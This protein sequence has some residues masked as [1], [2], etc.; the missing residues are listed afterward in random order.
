[1]NL[2][3]EITKRIINMIEKK[4]S[5]N[6]NI[7]KP[8]TTK[9]VKQGGVL[10]YLGKQKTVNAPRHWRSSPKHPI[11]HLS[12]ITKD[13]EKILIDLN[14]YGSL[15]GKPNR[16]PFG[17]PSLQGS[18][19]GSGG[20]GGSSGGDGSSSGDSSGDSSG[21][22]DSSGDGDSSG[23][24]DS[25]PGG[26]D[27]GSGHGGP[28]PGD[29]G[30][31]MG[32]LGEVGSLGVSDVSGMSVGDVAGTS[33]NAGMGGV[34]GSAVGA[35]ATAAAAE[36]AEESGL[37]K[38]MTAV[39]SYAMNPTT[40]GRAIG[41][42][43]FGIPGAVVGS[44]IGSNIG[45]GVTGPSDDTQEQSS[46]QTSAPSASD[47]GGGITTINQFAPLSN[48]TTGDNTA[49]SIR[50]RLNALLVQRPTSYGIP[51][52]SQLSNYNLLDLVNLRR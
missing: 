17:L 15:K 44:M 12:Y 8:S 32:G 9:P 49:D 47:G 1:M 27:E 20:D 28:G 21:E 35:A 33:E 13:E 43:T 10:N 39:K 7:E 26:S 2:Y 5:Y 40:I 19:G 38:A 45:R 3:S 14:L 34:A 41:M 18:G 29:S 22:G 24:G 51:A 4:I 46:V 30:P 11:A 23:E 36:A 50:T 42:A 52:A 31:G 48:P 16:G 25:G 37:S 6:I